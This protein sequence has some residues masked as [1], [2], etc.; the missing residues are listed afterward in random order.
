MFILQLNPRTDDR[1]STIKY[2]DGN[3]WVLNADDA[4]RYSRLSTATKS[5]YY[6]ARNDGS[7]R[8]RLQ[9]IADGRVTA[10][11]I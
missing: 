6:F 9:I 3:N 8:G 11:V 2:W 7:Y 5:F 1:H 10:D 4:L